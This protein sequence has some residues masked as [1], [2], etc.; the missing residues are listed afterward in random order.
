MSANLP[1]VSLATAAPAPRSPERHATRLDSAELAARFAAIRRQTLAL[2]APL[3]PEDCVIQPMADASPAKWH[4]AHTTWFFEAFVLSAQ[5]A[6]PPAFDPAFEF[7]FNSY[8]ETVGP[9]VERPRRGMLSRPGLDRVHAYRAAIDDHVLRAL[10]RGALDAA[11]LGVLELGLHHEQQHQELILT[12]AKYM[13]GT[14]PLQPAYRAFARARP[15]DPAPLAWHAEPGGTIE[16]GAPGT[17]GPTGPTGTAGAADPGFAFDNERPRHRVLIAPYRI[18]S[19]PIA[20]AEVLAFIADGGYRDHRLW[21]SDGWHVVKTEQWE[22]PLYWIRR[23]GDHA[24]YELAGVR[25]V[26]PGET[27][28]HLSLYEAD[29]IARWL[30]ARL[31]T[32]AEWEHAARAAALHG[33]FA[34]AGRL[35]PDRAEPTAA[36]ALGQLFGDVW[37]WTQS[38]YSPYPGFRPLAGALGEYNGKFMSGQNVLR[39]GSCFTPAGHIRRSYRNFFP[40]NARWQMTGVRLATDD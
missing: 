30:G 9:R 4:L 25:A 28:C 11:A 36:A 23:D 35:H 10:D 32:E 31:P 39:G 37:E 3:S 22:A 29:A 26:D 38:S 7:L 20:N 34:E 27:A 6:P 1:T 2:C 17:T 5:P 13:L 40:P 16:I 33:N 12:D 15:A 14:Q 18:A 21:L 19:R 8:Y 24:I